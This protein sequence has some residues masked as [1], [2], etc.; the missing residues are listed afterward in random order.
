MIKYWII[1]WIRGGSW[2]NRIVVSSCSVFVIGEVSPCKNNN[3][4]EMLLASAASSVQL[5]RPPPYSSTSHLCDELLISACCFV[6]PF[7]ENNNF[8]SDN[9]DQE[10]P[11]HRQS[12][13]FCE[14][15]ENSIVP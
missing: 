4:I 10:T 11:R 1:L 13:P 15:E 9:R 6:D 5:K 2:Q 7:T 3:V 12:E 8:L 14:L